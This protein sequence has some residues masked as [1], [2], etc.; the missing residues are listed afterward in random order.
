MWE[1]IFSVLFVVCILIF[2]K[3]EDKYRKYTKR[4]V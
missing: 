4:N 2:A 1:I 3:L